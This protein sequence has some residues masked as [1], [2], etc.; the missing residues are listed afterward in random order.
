MYRRI[1]QLLQFPP[2]F[3]LTM[4][5]AYCLPLFLKLYFHDPNT[6][7]FEAVPN[8]GQCDGFRD[9]PVVLI[10]HSLQQAYSC[11]T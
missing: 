6:K 7:N 4:T 5:S 2:Q 9:Y 8:E 11:I 10:S 3:P 1:Y